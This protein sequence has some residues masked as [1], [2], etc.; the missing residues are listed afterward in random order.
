MKCMIG[1]WTFKISKFAWFVQY[2][3]EAIRVAQAKH[4]AELD[5]IEEKHKKETEEIYIGKNSLPFSF[6]LCVFVILPLSLIINWINLS[7][8]ERICKKK[9]LDN[10]KG[11]VCPKA[12][13]SLFI[14]YKMSRDFST[15]QYITVVTK[16]IHSVHIY[17]YIFRIQSRYPKNKKF[18]QKPQ[19]SMYYY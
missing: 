12:V 5:E 19:G 11:T 13:L 14:L 3:V 1:L 6:S 16:P 8:T 10:N 2:K 4:E 15:V 9:W 7:F 18:L 17:I